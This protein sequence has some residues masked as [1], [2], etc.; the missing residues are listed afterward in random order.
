MSYL[1][2]YDTVVGRTLG[3]ASIVLHFANIARTAL[4]A[5]SWELQRLMGTSLVASDKKC[6][7]YVIMSS[8]VT[9]G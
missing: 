5:A 1:V 7:A 9:I 6:M 4:M 3:D 8:D 2:G